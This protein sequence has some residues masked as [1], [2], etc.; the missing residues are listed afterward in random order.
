MTFTIQKMIILLIL[1]VLTGCME[2]GKTLHPAYARIKHIEQPKQ[3]K[4]SQKLETKMTKHISKASAK[5]K[6]IPKKNQTLSVKHAD[7]ENKHLKTSTQSSSIAKQEKKTT[8]QTD[9]FTLD[10][11]TKKFLSGVAIFAISLL[12][13]L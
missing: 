3:T 8:Q 5:I 12:I 13:L 6:V 9:F 7:L 10:E 1:L 2:R 11:K 4:V